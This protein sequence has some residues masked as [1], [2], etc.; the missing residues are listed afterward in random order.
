[1]AAVRSSK[2]AAHNLI[3]GS[4]RSHPYSHILENKR[5]KTPKDIERIMKGVSNQR[6]IQILMLLAKHKHLTMDQI[7][8]AL[9][10]NFKTVSGHTQKLAQAGLIEKKYLG[11]AVLHSLSKRG[12]VLH[13]FINSF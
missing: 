12:R 10:C 9:E 2:R 5:I 13:D 8:Q 11:Q 7:S 6:R 4:S 1:M 3:F